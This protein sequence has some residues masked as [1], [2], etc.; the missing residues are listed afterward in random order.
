ME[1][2]QQLIQSMKSA[3]PLYATPSKYLLKEFS[4]MRAS[5]KL[6]VTDV[7]YLGNEGG[8]SCAI[9]K[10]GQVMVISVTHLKFPIGHPL[11]REID[12][13]KRNR[14]QALKFEKTLVSDKSGR[15]EPCT[16]GSGKKYKR[17]CG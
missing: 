2:D 14:M 16:C 17:C 5:D 10:A 3:L 4:E 6:E 9:K 12:A 8:I 7:H 15:N 1:N 13:Y 11:T